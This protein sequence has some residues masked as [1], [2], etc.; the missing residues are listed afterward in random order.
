[1]VL[2]KIIADCTINVDDI[3]IYNQIYGPDIRSLEVK[4][5]W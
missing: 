5:R 2:D 1:M 3:I 4:F